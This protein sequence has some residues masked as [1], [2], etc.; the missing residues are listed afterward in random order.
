MGFI[1]EENSTKNR[2]QVKSVVIRRMIYL[3]RRVD[4]DLRTAIFLKRLD[5]S[6]IH[7]YR[8]QRKNCKNIFKKCFFLYSADKH[9]SYTQN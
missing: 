1:K 6:A 8:S 3:R 4:V 7:K 5:S 2:E 9:G